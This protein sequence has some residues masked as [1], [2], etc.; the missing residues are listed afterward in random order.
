MVE[1]EGHDVMMLTPGSIFADGIADPY[2]ACIR[3][4]SKV[5]EVYRLRLYDFKLATSAV[6]SSSKW[7]Y[8]FN[9][10]EKEC[11]NEL[12]G[13]LQNMHG[14]IEGLAPHPREEEINAW[15]NHR[16][17]N[18]KL[19][20]Q[21]REGAD[22][23]PSKLPHIMRKSASE[24]TARRAEQNADRTQTNAFVSAAAKNRARENTHMLDSSHNKSD[25]TFGS[26]QKTFGSSQ[27]KGDMSFGTGLVAYPSFHLPMIPAKGGKST[28][29]A[30]QSETTLPS[31]MSET[32][33]RSA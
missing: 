25:M 10:L 13:R 30:S 17:A 16:I 23:V 11:N 28:L 22:E 1:M 33:I 8:R 15:R 20:H 9:L 6:A 19:A 27:K 4:T 18:I 29:H 21:R 5:C 31:T 7:L 2:G 12:R 26:S 24:P 32:T 14:V 3:A